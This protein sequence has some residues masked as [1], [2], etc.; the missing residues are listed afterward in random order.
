MRRTANSILDHPVVRAFISG[1]T[2]LLRDEQDKGDYG[3][4]EFPDAAG[5]VLIGET[6]VMLKDLEE[7]K[8]Q[9]I[10]SRASGVK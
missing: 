8:R 3:F 9:I 10:G 2:S 4:L 6:W 7:L 5:R 1:D